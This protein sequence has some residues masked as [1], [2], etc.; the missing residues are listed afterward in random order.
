MN[1]IFKSIILHNF[2][3]FGHSEINLEDKKYCLVSGINKCSKDN[4]ISNGSG[5]STIWSGIC[6]A[7][8]GETVQGIT[9]GIKNINIDKNECYVEL[10]FI[11]NKDTYIIKRV[12]EPK[13]ILTEKHSPRPER[14]SHRIPPYRPQD[15]NAKLAKSIWHIKS[16]LETSA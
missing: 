8:T 9:S 15:K 5:K 7:L 14:T 13:R 2:L 6:W 11:V 12:K 1:I 10:K 4:A 16:T 3:S